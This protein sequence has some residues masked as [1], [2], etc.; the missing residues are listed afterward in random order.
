MVSRLIVP[1]LAVL[2]LL[3]NATGAEY[4]C[5]SDPG[6]CYRDVGNDGCF[7][8]GVDDGPINSEIEEASTLDPTPPPGSLIC[9]PSVTSVSASDADIRLATPAGSS[10]LIYAARFNDV[11][12]L[13]I[14][15]GEDILFGGDVEPRR[16]VVLRAANDV[17]V[18]GDIDQRDSQV[19]GGLVLESS[20]GDVRIGPKSRLRAAGIFADALAG[21]IHVLEKSKLIGQWQSQPSFGSVSLVATG[22]LLIENAT[23]VA[24]GRQSIVDLIGATVTVADRLKVKQ[25]GQNAPLRFNVAA[26]AG[27]VAVDR[28]VLNTEAPITFSGE[29]VTIGAMKNGKIPRSKILFNFPTPVTGDGVAITATGAVDLSRLS[30]ITRD[31]AVIETTSTSLNFIGGTIKGKKATPTVNVSAGPASTCDLTGTVVKKAT[32]VTSCDAVVGP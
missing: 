26:L 19:N 29:N 4:P 9:P 13:E 12:E 25:R 17:L 14:V 28:L 15:S 5:P 8:S 32:L 7:D 3:G 20:S 23:I 30:L 27:D 22:N 18:E 6:F 31:D 2:L 1:L 11:H 10:V 21:E 16:F 24:I